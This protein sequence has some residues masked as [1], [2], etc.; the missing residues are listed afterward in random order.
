MDDCVKH[1]VLK[2]HPI[3]PNHD[4]GRPAGTSPAVT[5]SESG[6]TIN[7]A[8]GFISGLAGAFIG[9][10]LVFLLQV[11]VSRG[12]G[13][14]RYGLFVT[15]L[16]TAFMVQTL[17]SLGVQKGGMRFLAVAHENADARA[18]VQIFIFSV[19]VP[20]LFG[21]L[22]GISLYFL[23]PL[24]AETCFSNPDLVNV[25]KMFSF[26]IPFFAL[27]RTASDLTRSFQTAKYAVMVEDL[28]F[29][30]LHVAIFIA[31]EALGYG[32]S[33]VIQAFVAANVVCSILIM[34]LGWRLVVGFVVPPPGPAVR[35]Q[36]KACLNL[37]REVL[38]FSLPL[39]P[40]GLMFVFNSS[41]DVIMLNILTHSSEV[42]EY[43]AAARFG[44]LFALITLPMKLIFAPMIAGQ[45]GTGQMGQI[46]VLYKTSCRW[47]F[48]LSLP[49]FTFLAIARE[50]LMMIFGSG[51]VKTGPNIL[52]ILLIG[53][54]FASLLGVSADMLIMSGKQYFE[55]A[56]LGGGLLLNVL[57]NLMLIP[58]YGAIGAA[59]ATTT[60]SVATDTVRT[61]IVAGQYRMHPFSTRF[62][63][64]VIVVLVI[65]IGDFLLRWL[66][67]INP[68]GR[69]MMAVTL[70]LLV[71]IAMVGG[72]LA[73]EDQQL[74]FALKQKLSKT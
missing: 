18:M 12:Y 29:P 56:C 8:K 23:A 70:A 20:L 58:A 51:F 71:I 64:P 15:G 37:W 14:D 57:L 48:F 26:S 31:L 72:G 73:P 3:Q 13:P 47:M 67:T 62:T 21:S 19:S 28:L 24:I 41:L 59:I 16:L 68:I 63:L 65:F 6:I 55:L 9:K 36:H 66:C 2:L 45:Y 7:A 11:L 25:I 44:M 4:Q 34:K 49:L 38:I 69:S 5:R 50:P 35:M 61:L 30:T 10:A 60:S 17:S 40:M 43:A 33:S 22:A 53:S 54:L 74:F 52:A 46:E 1:E 27:L 32:F 39:L 42:G